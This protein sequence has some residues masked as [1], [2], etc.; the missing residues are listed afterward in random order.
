[1]TA[2][3][4]NE[5]RPERLELSQAGALPLRHSPLVVQSPIRAHAR[6]KSAE[7]C[8]QVAIRGESASPDWIQLCVSTAVRSVTVTALCRSR[9][10]EQGRTSLDYLKGLR[11]VQ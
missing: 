1:M 8:V 4:G 6:Q 7:Y 5:K 3:S 10:R 9:S 11:K 2:A